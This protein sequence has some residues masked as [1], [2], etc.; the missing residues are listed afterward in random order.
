MRGWDWKEHFSPQ[1]DTLEYLNY[2]ADKFDLRRDMQFHST[3]TS[4]HWDDAATKWTVTLESGQQAR[5]RFLLTAIGILSAHT[6]PAI[7]G[8]ESFSGPAYHPARWPHTPVDFTGKRVGIIGTGAT[9]IQAIPEIANRRS[10]SPS[11]SAGRTGR[12]RC[13]IPGSARKRWRRSSPATTRFTRAAP[14]PPCSSSTRATAARHWTCHPRSVRRTVSWET[15][16]PRSARSSSASR[17][18]RLTLVQPDLGGEPVAVVWIGWQLHI[19]NL[20]GFL[21]SQVTD[22]RCT[23]GRPLVAASGSNGVT[24]RRSC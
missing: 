15:T 7:P 19:A 22:G 17:R 1:P 23:H 9:A 12:R 10:S 20:A 18:L 2:V 16:T 3:V 8:V 21:C 13:T 5:S 6:M 4:A 24:N 11:S 14:R